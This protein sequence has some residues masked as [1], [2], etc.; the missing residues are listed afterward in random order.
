M[1]ADIS[2]GI[3]CYNSYWRFDYFDK[4]ITV[5]G[6]D[7]KIKFDHDNKIVRICF[8]GSK[9]PMDWE[10]DIMSIRETIDAQL[11]CIGDGFG[12][13]SRDIMN[14]LKTIVPEDYSVI[15]EG[16]SLGAARALIQGSLFLVNKIIDAKRIS[17]IV[18]GCPRPGGQPLL[19]IA[20]QAN[21]LRCYRN[22]S[23]LTSSTREIDFVTTVP[24]Q[25]MGAFEEPTPYTVDIGSQPVAIDGWP[26]AI[27]YH[28]VQAYINSLAVC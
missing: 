1:I 5:D 17:I 8:P 22:G 28:H 10:R 11:G 4:Q 7:V 25:A 20:A 12:I 27:K 2:T 9:S 24:T 6:V 15:F 14:L 16:H 26:L 19:Q 23:P 18:L 21:Y 3:S 13:G